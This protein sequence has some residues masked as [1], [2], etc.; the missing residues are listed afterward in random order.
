[1][2]K[3]TSMLLQT[4]LLLN[5][6]NASE[7]DSHLCDVV[8]VKSTIRAAPDSSSSVQGPAS[9]LPGGLIFTGESSV[10]GG[11]VA[12]S[13]TA[14]FWCVFFQTSGRKMAKIH[15][16]AF[17]FWIVVQI[18]AYLI[19]SEETLQKKILSLTLFTFLILQH[20][21]LKAVFSEWAFSHS[22]SQKSLQTPN[23]PVLFESITKEG[24]YTPSDLIFLWLLSVFSDLMIKNT[25]CIH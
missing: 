13:C 3:T 2:V 15:I 11:N 1:M 21:S 10:T 24:F 17:T 22:L 19:H 20:V 25:H 6:N 12:F 23:F 8:Q 5:V 4:L 7:S 18:S 16:E 14:Q 9:L